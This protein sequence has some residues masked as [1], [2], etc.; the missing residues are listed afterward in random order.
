MYCDVPHNKST[1]CVLA[2]LTKIRVTETAHE[3]ECMFLTP[4]KF[5]LKQILM[6]RF[7]C[8]EEY[9]GINLHNQ[10]FSFLPD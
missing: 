8:V 5:V 7:G 1:A 2:F 10:T 3:S 4:F 6:M 9:F